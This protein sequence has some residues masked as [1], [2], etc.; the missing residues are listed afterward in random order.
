[1][2]INGGAGGTGTFCIQIAKALGCR[3]TA[4][5]S[6]AK[7][8]LCEALG[9]DE[10]VDYT[11]EKDLCETLRAK[12]KVFKLCVDNVGV[13]YGLYKAADGFLVEGGRFVQ[14][15]LMFTWDSLGST[16]MRLLRPRV[17]GGGRHKFEAFLI[18]ED[19]EGLDRLARW[20]KEGEL[21]PV[22]E[23]VFEFGRVVEAFEKLKGGKCYGKLVV[24][25]KE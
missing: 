22:V 5:C 7:T 12:G 24:R 13:P 3:I 21:K 1:M 11:R 23:E 9:A 4:V 25:V 15:G 14:V 19:V 2:L 8:R 20:V 16:L 10:V 17:L 18:R 6:T